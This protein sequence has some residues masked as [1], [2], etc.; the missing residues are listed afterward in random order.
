MAHQAPRLALISSESD[1]V[2]CEAIEDAYFEGE[3][4][5]STARE[6]MRDGFVRMEMSIT[7]MGKEIE[8]LKGQIV[9]V[10]AQLQTVHDERTALRAMMRLVSWAGVGLV[11]LVGAGWALYTHLAKSQ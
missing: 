2:S 4:A 3:F 7:S 8:V 11:G 10:K 1:I 9:E 6:E 5:M